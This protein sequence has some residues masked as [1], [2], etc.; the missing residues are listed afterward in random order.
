M[1]IRKGDKWKTAFR[2]RYGHFKYLIIPFSLTNAPTTFQA[3]INKAL[4]GLV[5]QFCVVYLNDILIYSKTK[6]KH[7]DHVKQV[8]NRL[9]RYSLY[10]SLK[11]CEFFVTEVEFL[12]FIVSTTDI[13]IDKRRVAIIQ[14]WPK[15]KGYHNVQVFLE[16]VNFYRRFI[17]HYSQIAG[18]LTGLLK[19]SEKDI[20]SGPFLWPD[21]VECAFEELK[22]AFITAPLLKHFDP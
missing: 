18:P 12:G 15:P 10:V 11:K 19:G 7:L 14:E 3:Y 9:R 16:F 2:T 13:A 5:D 1:R 8:L 4:I 22:G 21:V 20:K 17:H 6:K